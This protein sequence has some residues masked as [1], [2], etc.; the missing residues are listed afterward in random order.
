MGIIAVDVDDTICSSISTQYAK[1]EI[2]FCKPY[3]KMIK[4]INDL[5]DRGNFIYIWTHRSKCCK[6]QTELWLKKYKVKYSAIEFD[7]LGANLYLDNKALPPFN[8]LNAQMIEDYMEQ[9]KKRNFEKGS[10][11]SKP[12]KKYKRRNL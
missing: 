2:K 7:K 3:K 12:R 8:Y 10:F 11:R 6:R 5:Y 4:V 9:I 1:K